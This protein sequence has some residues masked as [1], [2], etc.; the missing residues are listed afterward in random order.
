MLAHRVCLIAVLD[1]KLDQLPPASI[2]RGG[3]DDPVLGAR[4]TGP[5]LQLQRSDE[6]ARRVDLDLEL[7]WSLDQ[8]GDRFDADAPA[9][10]DDREARA[11]LPHLGQHVARARK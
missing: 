7:A 5:G 8:L 4:L 11:Y 1:E 3:D 2:G 6:L 10:V 9:V